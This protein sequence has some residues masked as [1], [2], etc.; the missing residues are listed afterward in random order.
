M[1]KKHLG[2]HMAQ[3]GKHDLISLV[4]QLDPEES[5]YVNQN[6]SQVLNLLSEIRLIIVNTT[7]QIFE[8]IY[9]LEKEATLI[10]EQYEKRVKNLYGNFRNDDDIYKEDFELFIDIA[11]SCIDNFEFDIQD[12]LKE[13]M[14][15]Y[16]IEFE[17]SCYPYLQRRTSCY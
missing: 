12:A 7:K 9:E 14:P 16:N 4:S 11:N 8:S 6:I 15:L 13:V 10:I 2:L 3:K 1:C 5:E 17:K